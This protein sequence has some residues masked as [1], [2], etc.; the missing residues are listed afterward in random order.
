MSLLLLLLQFFLP[1]I[2]H[3]HLEPLAGNPM[4]SKVEVL[5][6][7]ND[8]ESVVLSDLAAHVNSRVEQLAR[9]LRVGALLLSSHLHRGVVVQSNLQVDG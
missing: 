5:N 6:I 2:M 4:V 7:Q 1:V 8:P 9:E 3:C